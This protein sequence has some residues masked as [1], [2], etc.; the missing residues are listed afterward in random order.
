MKNQSTIYID[1]DGVI[2]DFAGS[3]AKVHNFP[4]EKAKTGQSIAESFGLT[5][6]EF[7]SPIDDL[8]SLFW[9]G[10]I[11]SGWHTERFVELTSDE[12]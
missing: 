11:F 4:I 9:E 5:N 3:A 10:K 1:M 12:F 6:K 2:A 8:G 7:W